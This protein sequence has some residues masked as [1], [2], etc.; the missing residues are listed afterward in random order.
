M[1]KHWRLG[2]SGKFY[3][4]E[5]GY[6]LNYVIGITLHLNDRTKEKLRGITPF[7]LFVKKLHVAAVVK[8]SQL[9][10]Q[11]EKYATKSKLLEQRSCDFEFSFINNH[12]KLFQANCSEK[13]L[14]QN[15]LLYTMHD[16]DS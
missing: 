8:Y 4:K 5:I 1:R 15:L 3:Q 6:D 16:I 10:I 12:M 9:L 11:N 13:Y 2:E 7:L 14:L